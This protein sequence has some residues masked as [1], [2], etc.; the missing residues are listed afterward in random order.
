MAENSENNAVDNQ[1]TEDGGQGESPETL[2][3]TQEEFDSMLNDHVSKAVETAKGDWDK[4]KQ[5]EITKAQ[6]LAQMSEKDRQE[7]EERARIDKLNAREQE[8]NM[9]EYKYTAKAELENMGMSDQFVDMV[10]SDNPETT[11]NNINAL[12]SAFDKEVEIAV[13]ERLKG[14]TPNVGGGGGALTKSQIMAVKDP[15][16]RQRLI[17]ENLNLFGK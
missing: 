8:L 4:E 6:E 10:L 9:R 2:T 12:K 15:T 14:S 13:K 7:A 1:G 17:G 3:F 11:K 16:E 5:V